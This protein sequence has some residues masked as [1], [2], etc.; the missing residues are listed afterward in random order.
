MRL[1]DKEYTLKYTYNAL[2]E[3]EARYNRSLIKDISAGG[4]L[5]VRRLIFA[6][7]MHYK[8]PTITENAVG[9][10]IEKELE[11]GEKD[12]IDLK[13]EISDAVND[14]VFIQ[15]LTDRT[16]ARRAASQQRSGNPSGN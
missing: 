15:R 8:D 5:P 14:A 13:K 12:L 4:Y 1:G 11:T 9:E 2:A 16:R 7:L 6:G 3:Y 10:M